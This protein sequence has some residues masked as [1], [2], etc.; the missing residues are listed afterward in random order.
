[1]NKDNMVYVYIY[2]MCMCVGCVCVCKG[3]IGPVTNQP[4]IYLKIYYTQLCGYQSNFILQRSINFWTG[5]MQ[6]DGRKEGKGKER[7]REKINR[8][9]FYSSGYIFILQ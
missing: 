9:C 4:Q 6:K 5:R 1:M 7:V 8:L 2:G 3:G